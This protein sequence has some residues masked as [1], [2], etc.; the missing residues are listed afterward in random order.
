MVYIV[1]PLSSIRN[2][3]TKLIES[4]EKELS[5]VQNLAR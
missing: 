1:Q 5:K 3:N 2:R 4:Y